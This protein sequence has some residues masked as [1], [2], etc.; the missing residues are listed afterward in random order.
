M[1]VRNFLHVKFP[2]RWIGQHGLKSKVYES[3]PQNL[4][5]LRRKFGNASQLVTSEMLAKAVL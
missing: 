1:Q 5:D 2:G 3:K 4:E